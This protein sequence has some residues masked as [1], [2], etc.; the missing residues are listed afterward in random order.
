MHELSH[1]SNSLDIFLLVHILGD[2]C[3]MHRRHNP[4]LKLLDH[5]AV[6]SKIV[7]GYPDS[8]N[9]GLPEY[10]VI[11]GIMLMGTDLVLTSVIMA[12]LIF[13]VPFFTVITIFSHEN[14]FYT[15]QKPILHLYT[16]G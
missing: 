5:Y 8:T 3:K 14:P 10:R 13:K 1:P 4:H 7:E 15:V 11:R 6:E 9:F 2:G 12:N 16:I